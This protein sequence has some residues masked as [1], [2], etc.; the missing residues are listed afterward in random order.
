MI[1]QA[2]L[3]IYFAF[4][5]LHRYPFHFPFPFRTMY[6]QSYGFPRAIWNHLQWIF[7]LSAPADNVE[8]RKGIITNL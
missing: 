4:F 1:V 5:K 6:F 7:G 2:I 8:Q 3:Q